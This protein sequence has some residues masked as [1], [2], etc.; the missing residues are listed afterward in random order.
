MRIRNFATSGLFID[1][2]MINSGSI[3]LMENEA[4][5]MI[6]SGQAENIR[7]SVFDIDGDTV[8]EKMSI[9]SYR[10]VVASIFIVNMLADAKGVD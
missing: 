6:M 5:R 4:I 10:L 1:G 7:I 3:Q 9:L 8:V 2:R